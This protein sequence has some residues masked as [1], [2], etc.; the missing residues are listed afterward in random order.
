MEALLTS[1]SVHK[2]TD[3]STHE[4]SSEEIDILTYVGGFILFRTKKKFHNDDY[5]NKVVNKMIKKDGENMTSSLIVAKNR[6]GL[7][8]PSESII[9]FFISCEKQFRRKFSTF[10]ENSQK[11]FIEDVCGNDD[12]T[13]LFY[14]ATSSHD[15]STE[16]Q[17]KIIVFILGL[18]FRV[19]CHAKCRQYLEKQF[20]KNNSTK[21][22]KALRKTITK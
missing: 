10:R 1:S 11:L 3:E 17:E 7:C 19:R 6:G 15:S 14:Q 2:P 12:T 9:S 4:L 20:A 5:C 16:S 8:E 13:S 21:K 18:F 22:Q